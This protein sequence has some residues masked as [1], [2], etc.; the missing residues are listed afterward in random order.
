MKDTPRPDF[1]FFAC[2]FGKQKKPC[3]GPGCHQAGAAV[4]GFELGGRLAGTKCGRAVCEAHGAVVGDKVVC[5]PHQRL[6]ARRV[7]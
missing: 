1:T 6:A 5:L 4:C 7:G 2:D 3:T